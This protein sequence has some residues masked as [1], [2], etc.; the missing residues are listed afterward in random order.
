[1]SYVTN[2][3]TKHRIFIKLFKYL[4]PFDIPLCVGDFSPQDILLFSAFSLHLCSN[5]DPT[6]N[7]DPYFNANSAVTAKSFEIKGREVKCCEVRSPVSF[8]VV[9]LISTSGSGRYFGMILLA[10]R[11]SMKHNSIMYRRIKGCLSLMNFM[12]DISTFWAG[13]RSSYW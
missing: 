8:F 11:L 3:T 1:M 13:N 10:D 9:F 7:S 2:N 12:V 4:L 5:H 6:T